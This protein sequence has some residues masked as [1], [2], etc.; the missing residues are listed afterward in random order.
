MAYEP[1][2]SIGTGKACGLKRAEKMRIAIKKVAGKKTP[3]LYGGSVNSQN[4]RQYIKD[5][6]FDGLLVGGASLR[7]K[8][9][10]DSF[11]AAC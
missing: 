1:L 7:P 2:F 10:I 5:G 9:F 3:I 8:E 4:A 11:K 6:G